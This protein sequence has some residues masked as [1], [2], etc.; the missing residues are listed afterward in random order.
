MPI[1]GRSRRHTYRVHLFTLSTFEPHPLAK[2][3]ILFWPYWVT[4]LRSAP[5]I[6]IQDGL[7]ALHANAAEEEKTEGG[8]AIYDWKRGVLVAA[9]PSSETEIIESFSFIAPALFLVA[10]Y[11]VSSDKALLNL[12][13]FDPTHTPSNA[14]PTEQAEGSSSRPGTP[15]LLKPAAN[16]APT[17]IATYHL[18][19]LRHRPNI[20]TIRLDPSP[21]VGDSVP[22]AA[23]GD[24]GD[25]IKA[26]P[27]FMP[28]GHERIVLVDLQFIVPDQLNQCES[29][30]SASSVAVVKKLTP[31]FRTRPTL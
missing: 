14:E 26:S 25:E 8:V 20:F 2:E 3:Q 7:V 12:Y 24:E 13:A 16:P 6:S 1:P 27:M 23:E 28:D 9:Q 15:S 19:H 17:L 29:R 21:G 18:P 30:L 10:V 11:N 22:P 31:F 5:F 4:S